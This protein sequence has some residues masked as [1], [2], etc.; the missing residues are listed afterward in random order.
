MKISINKTMTATIAL[1]LMLTMVAS[2]TCLPAANAVTAV[3]DRPTGAYIST[4]PDL[5][6]LG[7]EIT[8][9]AWIYPS[10]AGP[11]Y[12]MGTALHGFGGV[13]GMHFNNL[14]VTFTRPDGS[15]DTFMPLDGSWEPLGLVAGM[16]EEVGTMWFMYKPNQIGTW[17]VSCSYPGETFTA[18]NYSVYYKP[19]TSRAITFEVQQDL[20]QIGLPPV[21][22]PTGYWERPIN[23]QNREWSSIAGDWLSAA[24]GPGLPGIYTNFNPYTTAPNSAHI[25]WKLDDVGAAPGGIAG[26]AYGSLSYSAGAITPYIWN[27]RL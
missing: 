17:S 26:G 12:E 4:N 2:L 21:Q 27:G 23:A 14:K 9:N 8:V 22:L 19:S 6:G 16:T 24:D 7:Q 3:P 11:N 5:V 10:P 13:E 15:K 20:V 1:I 25:L 18:K